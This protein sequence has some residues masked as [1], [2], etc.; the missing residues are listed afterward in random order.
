MSVPFRWSDRRLV[1]DYP[2]RRGR[3]GRSV[4]APGR[5]Q[6]GAHGV[7]FERGVGGRRPARGILVGMP[8]R[9]LTPILACAV[10]LAACGGSSEKTAKGDSQ[11]T[12]PSA[13]PAPQG[14]TGSPLELPAD[15]PSKPTGKADPGQVE[16]I[17][18][19]SDALRRGDVAAASAT[20]AV[21][22]KVQNGSPV[23][24]LSSRSEVRIFNDAL[25]C[26]SV[27]TSAG[28]ARGGFTIATVRL[29]KRK[30]ADCG[31]GTGH[32]ARTAILVRGGKIAEW[33][34]L[35][36]DPD[37]PRSQAQPDDDPADTTV[38]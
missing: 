5:W 15:V 10:L 1:C 32:S 23:L 3:N 38:I 26:G 29:T 36:D 25:S 18:A 24:T 19:W 8:P 20:W 13:A 30:G 2:H 12:T 4:L 11:A 16:V 31:T 27:V 37:A 22:S 33:Y 35:P 14:G 9:A 6:A 28:A 17:R 34:R 21:P 7:A